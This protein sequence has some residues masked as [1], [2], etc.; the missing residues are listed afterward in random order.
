MIS[1]NAINTFRLCFFCWASIVLLGCNSFFFE[2]PTLSQNFRHSHELKSSIQYANVMQTIYI[3]RPCNL[4][5]HC[6]LSRRS[7]ST[8]P[9]LWY[10]CVVKIQYCGGGGD[11]YDPEIAKSLFG[12]RPPDKF[13]TQ[14]NLTCLKAL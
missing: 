10:S 4:T 8:H 12:L 9:P 3:T 1:A 7:F 5:K 2:T 13:R 14:R 6:R 11:L